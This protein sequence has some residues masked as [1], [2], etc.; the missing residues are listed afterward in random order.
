M[1]TVTTINQP[2]WDVKAVA[3]LLNCS[4]DCVRKMAQK[5][6]IPARKIGVVGTHWRF[7][8]SDVEA[9]LNEND[10]NDQR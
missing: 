9:W 2:L 3:R 4:T 5:G 8:P 7:R 10:G 6:L 1:A